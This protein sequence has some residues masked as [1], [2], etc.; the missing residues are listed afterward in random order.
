MASSIY[1]FA[2]GAG[3]GVS[4]GGPDGRTPI[5][6]A[7]V[8]WIRTAGSPS[9]IVY[10][11]D[12]YPDG[13]SRNFAEFFKQMD[14]DVRLICE[15]PG[16]H[17]WRDD[18]EVPGIGRIPHGYET[19]W[20]AHPESKQPIDTSKKG[21]ARYDHFI[22]LDGWRLFFLDTGDYN[23]HPWPGGD[24]SRVAW[25]RTNLL[26]GRSNLIFA[27]HSRLSRGRHGNNDDLDRLWQ[28]LFDADGTPRAS[29]MVGGHDHSIGVYKPRS[30]NNPE[31]SPVPAANGIPIVVNGAGGDGHYSQDGFLGLFVSGTKPDIMADDE[32][33]FV[34]R[35]RLIDARS[36]DVDMIDFGTA[37]RRDPTIKN[38]VLEIRL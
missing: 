19:F 30:R 12:V 3:E 36:A 5:P 26:P 25:L 1:W 22:D 7:L 10:G 15:T 28:S 9:L 14:N 11:G 8:R 2:D 6:T 32:R 29:L 24:E 35:I 18:P 20:K 33:F 34:T 23:A 13:T 4:L 17:D 27:H 38:G 21:A 37:A 31:G 16:N